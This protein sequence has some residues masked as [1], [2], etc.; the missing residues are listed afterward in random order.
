MNH[1]VLKNCFVFNF[2]VISLRLLFILLVSL[3]VDTCFPAELDDGWKVLRQKL[4][5]TSIYFSAVVKRQDDIYARIAE[6]HNQ[7]I[8][9]TESDSKVLFAELRKANRLVERLESLKTRFDGMDAKIQEILEDHSAAVERSYL[10][11]DMLDYLGKSEG[12]DI[13]DKLYLQTKLE[14]LR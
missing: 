5:Q 7:F 12:V 8:A 9:V 3:W 2:S 1:S 11:A 4:V 6:L 14:S 13:Q 10:I